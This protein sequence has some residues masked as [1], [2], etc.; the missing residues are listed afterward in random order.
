MNRWIAL[1]ETAGSQRSP[2]DK[3]A[4]RK[5][6]A[7][8][9]V[10]L[11]AKPGDAVVL[12]RSGYG[13]E[14]I[15]IGTIAETEP[16]ED[17]GSSIRRLLDRNDTEPQHIHRYAR[18]RY[19][20]CM[21]STPLTAAHLEANGL[22]TIRTQTPPGGHYFE[23]NP[24][25]EAEALQISHKQW[26]DLTKLAKTAPRP[27]DWPTA[28]HL[29]PGDTVSSRPQIHTVY[30]GNTRARIAPSAKTP[31]LL[32]FVDPDSTLLQGSQMRQQTVLH[33]AG[34]TEYEHQLSGENLTVLN[35][36]ERGL[37]LR[38]FQFERPGYR[39]L[40][41]C[42]IAQDNPI[43]RWE[44]VEETNR[45]SGHATSRYVPIFRL[46][47]LEADRQPPTKN[48][49]AQQIRLSF[50]QSVVI[51]KT[52]QEHDTV[53]TDPAAV[54]ESVLM[55]RLRAALQ[56]D[57][58]AASSLAAL[59]DAQSVAALIQLAQRRSDLAELRSVIDEPDSN[60]PHIQKLLQRMPWLFGGEFLSETARRRLTAQDQLDMCLIRA[61]GAIHG[62]ELKK[63]NIEKL[64][65]RRGHHLFVGGKV[66]DAVGQAINYLRNL[67]EQRD[68]I[69]ND[70]HID[71]RRASITVVIG[72]TSFVSADCDRNEILETIRTYNS[73]LSRVSVI[74]YDTLVDNAERAQGW[75]RA[76][77]S[78]E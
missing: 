29:D 60:E 41:E 2:S 15:A 58:A 23:G 71:C 57:P 64:I 77:S 59:G 11:A 42:M 68:R 69:L 38:P 40:G 24:T 16:I 49:P 30:G 50:K 74:T 3:D 33:V 10:P 73:H 27:V 46:R 13:G 28:W 9:V 5:L 7:T 48:H 19:E 20:F 53:D 56:R 63:A 32:I 34:M 70:F 18:I 72:H 39:Y 65:R 1:T 6:G 8:V 75:M 55:H 44:S 66:N 54:G 36:I 22:D 62:V 78:D 17:F 14:V 12:W 26:R 25:P 37:S 67:D 52:A 51:T 45:I 61:D 21:M 76:A 4:E 35:H 43:D 31:N 47:P